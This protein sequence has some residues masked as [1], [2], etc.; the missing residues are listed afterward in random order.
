[1]RFYQPFSFT[2]VIFLNEKNRHHAI[3]V[4]R[5][6]IGDICY[7]FDGCG[8]EVKTR[9]SQI[10]KKEVCV[11][12]LEKIENSSESILKIRLFQ[13]LCKGEKMDWII[14]KSVELGVTDITP[15]ITE[16]CDI[17]L[18]S[19]RLEKKIEHWRNIVISAAE[20]S[21][22][23]VLPALHSVISLKEAI[24]LHSDT[25]RFL[26]TPSA[27][28]NIST[29]GAGHVSAVNIYIGP[30]GGFSDY[31]ISFADKEGVYCVALGKRV[32]RTETAPLVAISVMQALWG[33]FL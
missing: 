9:I 32:L 23:A 5:C 11:E 30:E 22:R 1:M 8:N 10:S 15:I 19:D 12:I 20:Q 33:D 3:N 4:M 29:V 7:L 6:R 31:E 18:S 25:M 28:M 14:Q 24:S 2:E 16:R 13:A 21:G 26:L 17:K 27:K